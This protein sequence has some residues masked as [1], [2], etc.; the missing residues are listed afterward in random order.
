MRT[1]GQ[2]RYN[3]RNWRNEETEDAWYLTANR[4]RL[5]DGSYCSTSLAIVPRNRTSHPVCED[6]AKFLVA[7]WNAADKLGLS[8]E[9]LNADAIGRLVEAAKRVVGPA[10]KEPIITWLPDGS[11]QVDAKD[12]CREFLANWCD[13][14]DALKPFTK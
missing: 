3:N 13:L 8:A 6:N 5:N 14:E 9:Q 7:S 4:H 12:N 1:P 11:P 10:K 2:A